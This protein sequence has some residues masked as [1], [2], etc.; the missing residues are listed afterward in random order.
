MIRKIISGGETGAGR[1]A[2]DFAIEMGIPHGGWISRGRRTESGRL[3]EGYHLMETAALD[4]HQ[5]T[6]L[7]VVDSDG[8]LIIS[9]GKLTGD[10]ALCQDLSRKHRRSCLH[11]DLS[12]IHASKA[13]EIVGLWIDLKK[14][15][16]LNVAGPCASEDKEIYDAAKSLLWKVLERFLPKTV[17]EAVELLLSQM[18]LKDKSSIARFHK[19]ELPMLHSTLGTWII[20]RFGL[21]TGNTELIKSCAHVANRADLHDQ[22]ASSVII[23]ELWKKLQKTHSIRLIE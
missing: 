2:L 16:V 15:A 18:S 14:I 17:E 6:E 1:A 9:H 22:E 21:S 3:P 12:E 20:H 7:N 13:A 10:A 8:T 19:N 11:I 23:A 5:R 4:Y